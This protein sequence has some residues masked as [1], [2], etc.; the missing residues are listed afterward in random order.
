[1]LLS[2]NV[3]PLMKFIWYEFH[4]YICTVLSVLLFSL[5]STVYNITVLHKY[6]TC[7]LHGYMHRSSAESCTQYSMNC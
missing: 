4:V 7:T 1:M 6:I 5:L 2:S 3:S